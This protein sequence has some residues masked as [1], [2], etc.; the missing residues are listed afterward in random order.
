M[1]NLFVY[2]QSCQIWSCLVICCPVCP[3]LPG[4]QKFH[5]FGISEFWNPRWEFLNIWGNIAKSRQIWPHPCQVLPNRAISRQF[6]ES[7]VKY[8]RILPH[9]VRSSHVL[10]DLDRSC[11]IFPNLAKS[12]H[13]LPDVYRN[14][15]TPRKLRHSGIFRISE[16]LGRQLLKMW[17]TS[18]KFCPILPHRAE[19]LPNRAKSCQKISISR[20]DLPDDV[21]SPRIA[22]SRVECFQ[23]LPYLPNSCQIL[24][25]LV[26]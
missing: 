1:A 19:N 9:S 5:S 3:N 23:L 6:L 15:L 8:W 20:Q 21:K 14:S 13:F 7:I 12:C 2:P 16:F 25:C 22:P 24:S 4:L 11:R 17:G 10:S 26:R 18:S